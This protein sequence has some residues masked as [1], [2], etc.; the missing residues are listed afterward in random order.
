MENWINEIN[1]S[2]IYGGQ[3]EGD[4]ETYTGDEPVFNLKASPRPT[5]AFY[6]ASKKGLEELEKDIEKIE[7]G[8][9]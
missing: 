6:G 5:S 3:D 2:E 4:V 7:Q 8:R 1:E 9:E